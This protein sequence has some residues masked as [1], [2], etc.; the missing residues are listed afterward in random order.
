MSATA[1]LAGGA[2]SRIGSATSTI[3]AGKSATIRFRLTSSARARLRR[4]RTVKATLA[5]TAKHG[6][7]S[8]TR[9]VQ[10]TLKRAR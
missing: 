2:K 9:T 6:S 1:R 10:L 8:A 5:I 4:L 3:A 7:A